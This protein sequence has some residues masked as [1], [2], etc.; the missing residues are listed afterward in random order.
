M[1]ELYDLDD[2]YARFGENV[3]RVTNLIRL[4][5]NLG[6]GARGRRP[7]HATDVLRSAVVLL[8]ASLEEFLR[9][10]AREGLVYGTE[11]AL[12]RVPLAGQGRS[13]KPFS[14]SRLQKFRDKTVDQLL[15]ASIDAYL[16]YETYNNVEQIHKLLAG[17]R[18]DPKNLDCDWASIGRMMARRHKVVHEAD[19]NPAHGPQG[20]P[21]TEQLRVA[22]VQ[23][24]IRAVEGLVDQLAGNPPNQS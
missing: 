13:T 11:K 20:Q 10:V 12:D 21:R 14:L 24:W 2:A 16:E 6:G 8:H 9:A 19:R 5:D 1:P 3:G 23:G 17:V 18:L 4:Y 15:T 7:T 22:T